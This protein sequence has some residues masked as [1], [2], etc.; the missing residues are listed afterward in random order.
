M[1]IFRP[2]ILTLFPNGTNIANFFTRSMAYLIDNFIVFTIKYIFWIIFNSLWFYDAMVNFY[3]QF[4]STFSYTLS[5]PLQQFEYQEMLLYAVSHSFFVD[6]VFVVI[7]IFAIGATYYIF[8]HYKYQQTFG[9]K[10]LGIKLL[11]SN[12]DKSPSFIKV[13]FRYLVGLVPWV[14][15]IVAIIFVLGNQA[16]KGMVVFVAL[17]LWYDPLVLGRD[18]RSVHDFIAFTK[19]IKLKP[20][21]KK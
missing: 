6:F 13:V 1:N 14:A 21:Q 17:V 16:Q 19:V 4:K 8:M 18:R 11:D 20:S 15:M 3:Y 7:F 9:K 10:A 12:S 5:K 2:K